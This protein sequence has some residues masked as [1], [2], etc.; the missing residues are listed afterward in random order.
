[1]TKPEISNIFKQ[2]NDWELL[3]SSDSRKKELTTN[4]DVDILVNKLTGERVV[5][6]LNTT[7]LTGSDRPRPQVRVF[8]ERIY[9]A[10]EV[11]QEHNLRFFCFILCTTSP[12]DLKYAPNTTLDHHIISVEIKSKSMKSAT[13]IDI[14]SIVDHIPNIGNNNIFRILSNQH[15]CTSSIGQVSFINIKDSSENLILDS[16]SSYIDIFDN[17]PYSVDVGNAQRPVFVP[18]SLFESSGISN[19]SYPKNLLVFGAPGTGKSYY[20]DEKIKQMRMDLKCDV[21]YVRTTFYDGYTYGKFVG[22]YRPA[23]EETTSKVD[24]VY[25]S[26]TGEAFVN[27][28]QISYEFNAGPFAEMLLK[29][30]ISKARGEN[31]KY[32]I[33]IEELNRADAAS[34]FGDIFQILD[35]DNNGVSTY[36]IKPVLEFL[37][38]LNSNLID[39]ID[40]DLSEIKLPDNLYIWATM[41]SADQNVH[42]LDSAFKRRWSFLYMPLDQ[43][44]KTGK[45]AHIWLPVENN[46]KYENHCFYWDELRKGINKAILDTGFDE[47]RCIGYWFF[48]DEEMTQIKEYSKGLIDMANNADQTNCHITNMPN[49]LCDKLMSYLRQDVFRNNPTRFFV[50]GY[51]NMTSIRTALNNLSEGLINITKIE[52]HFYIDALSVGVINENE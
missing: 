13:R 26:Q 11:S 48:N 5:V 17:R 19:P 8:T 6:S 18:A 15:S 40:G 3:M 34:V 4:N 39:V 30:Y 22:C 33:I 41:N 35:R 14:R 25:A 52:K 44:A 29:A 37:N 31:K 49:P 28:T 50:D 38:Y 45:R 9:D 1:M 24:I 7:T 27:K 23:P 16:L 43:G 21:E 12:D 32:V 42:M 36:S 2:L 20:L 47:D 51:T 46:G 10:F